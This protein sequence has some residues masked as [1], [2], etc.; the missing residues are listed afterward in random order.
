MDTTNHQ[1]IQQVSTQQEALSLMD[2]FYLY[3][4]QWKWFVLSVLVCLLLAYGYIKTTHPVYTR[5]ISILLKEEQKGSSL[6]NVASE[7]SGMGF[8]QSRVN[9]NNE[10]INFQSPDL[11]FEV[12]KRLNLNVNYE[13]KG[14]YFNKTLYGNDLPITVDIAGLGDRETAALKITPLNN[15]EVEI[16]EMRKNQERFLDLTIRARIGSSVETPIG[17]ISIN[18]SSYNRLGNIAFDAPILVNRTSFY[19]ARAIYSGKLDVALTNKNSTVIDLT[20]NDLHIQRAE[21][22]LNTIVNVYNE[23]WIKDKNEISL[24]T[25]QFIAERLV[26]IEKDLGDVDDDI[27]DF[28]STN[29]LPDISAIAAISLQQS[30]EASNRVLELNNQK[31]I[32]KYLKN[33]ISSSTNQLLPAN[34]GLASDNV[35][36]NVGEYNRLMLE[37]NQLVENS[38]EA[39][40]LVQD[41]DKKLSEMK[42]TIIRSI[43]NYIV[44]LDLELSS[45]KT[46]QNH[47]DQRISS[48]PKQ[49]GK[50]LSVERQQKVKEALY[51][52][53]LQ[54]REENEMSQAFSAYN[55]R[56]VK[57][58]AQSGGMG[59]TAPNHNQI[60]LIGLALG[61]AIPAGL[62]YL[63]EA[64]ITTV[65]GRKDLEKMKIPFVGEIPESYK[66]K[67]KSPIAGLFVKAKEEKDKPQIIVKARSRS[68]IN[69]AFRVVRTNLEFVCGKHQGG[70]IIMITSANPGSGKTFT[71]ANLSNAMAVKGKKV[72]AIDLDIRKVSLSAY[73]DKPK[74]GVTEF[75]AGQVNDY[76]SLIIHNAAGSEIDMLPGGTIPPNPAEL[77]ADSKLD[78]MLEELRKEYDYIFLDC[79]P[80]EVVTDAAIVAPRADYT[81]FVIRAGLMEK[82]LLPE[83]DKF[84]VTQKYNNLCLILNGTDGGGRYGYKYG[85]KYGYRYGNSYESN[86]ED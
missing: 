80:V 49:A 50:L 4:S 66:K 70:C 13:K 7:F 71:T 67:K 45:A 34:A 48:N 64:M 85:Y 61:L 76:K 65:R 26:V 86:E 10:I 33:Y 54:K 29:M 44:S 69:E 39:N 84:Y 8:G 75:L 55:T 47:A 81:L 15:K 21:E 19:T 20:I 83:I 53:L 58:P 79:P 35:Q 37:R 22:V 23:N 74:V 14:F 43:D 6:N 9:I 1:N 17:Q 2:L 18:E 30:S 63:K 11:M 77:L 78:R 52:F 42:S 16:S 41:L 60:L 5:S 51:L 73:V 82:S 38:S 68:I 57:T 32:A 31:S 24:S 46:V 28:K 3:L 27:S 72:I 59:P 62:L 12:V 36:G 40:L 56:I 25:N